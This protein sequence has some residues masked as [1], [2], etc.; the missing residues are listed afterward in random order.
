MEV[1]RENPCPGDH[2]RNVFHSKTFR[3]RA[4]TAKRTPAKTFESDGF[5]IIRCPLQGALN[6]RRRAPGWLGRQVVIPSFFIPVRGTKKGTFSPLLQC[7][8]ILMDKYPLSAGR[9]NLILHSTQKHLNVLHTL[10]ISTCT[11]NYR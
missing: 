4:D 8:E 5:P 11:R 1:E 10:P 6:W 9:G 2:L 3:W 7:G